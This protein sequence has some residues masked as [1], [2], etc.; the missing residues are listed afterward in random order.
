MSNQKSSK[1]ESGADRYLR[2]LKYGPK[3][4]RKNLRAMKRAD[5]YIRGAESQPR[6]TGQRTRARGT[7]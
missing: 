2:E 5:A 3:P 6:T 7:R 1:P 4:T